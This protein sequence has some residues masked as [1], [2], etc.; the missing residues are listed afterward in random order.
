MVTSK[1][2]AFLSTWKQWDCLLFKHLPLLVL[3][4]V[5]RVNGLSQ[6]VPMEKTE[7]I[8]CRRSCDDFMENML[9][10]KDAVIRR[11]KNLPFLSVEV[12]AGYI[13]CRRRP[14]PGFTIEQ[15]HSGH[16]TIALRDVIEM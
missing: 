3:R 7:L 1:H 16:A 9:E 4:V 2:M 6:P 15:S 14:K 11:D 5:Q 13:L 10:E 8:M 12:K